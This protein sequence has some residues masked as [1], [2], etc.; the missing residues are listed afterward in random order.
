M[1]RECI[2]IDVVCPF[3]S[4]VDK[5]EVE[6][7]EKYQDLKREL[8]MIWKCRKICIIPIMTGALRTLSRNFKFWASKIEVC[9]HVD[10]MQ[11]ACVLGTAKTIRRVL[12]I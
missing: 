4:R 9:D 7:I 11:K 12:N 10:L 8:M 5:K 3:D 2:I 1:K 6:K